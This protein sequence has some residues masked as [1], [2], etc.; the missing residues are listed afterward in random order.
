M[1]RWIALILF[2][3]AAFAVAVIGGATTTASVREWYPDL[4][5]PSWNPPSWVFGPAW[6]LLYILMS[7]A[8]WRVWLRRAELG[9]TAN[10][11][12]RLHGIQLIL[13]ALWSVLFFGLRRPDLALIEIAVL[14]LVL[15]TIQ[16]RLFRHD[17]PAAFLWLPYLAWVT[18]A[19]V[20]NLTIWRLN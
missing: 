14:W 15:A 2:L 7:I 11:T 9:H 13:N 4:I 6:T 12:L 5:K 18:F 3:L 16:F 19:S 20:L 10:T 1:N 8:A 17:R